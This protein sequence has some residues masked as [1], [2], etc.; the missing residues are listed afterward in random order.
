MYI[1]S[2][3]QK[4]F[5]QKKSKSYYNSDLALTKNEK[6]SLIVCIFLIA[7]SIFLTLLLLFIS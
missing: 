7:F 5:E 6:L 1:L 2:A 3:L 4:V